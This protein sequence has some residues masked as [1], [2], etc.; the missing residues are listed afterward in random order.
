MIVK[1]AYVLPLNDMSIVSINDPLA[2]LESQKE[3][4]L[5]TAV[6][7]QYDCF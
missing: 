2:N 7:E 5:Y 3:L 6:H 4:Q 1:N